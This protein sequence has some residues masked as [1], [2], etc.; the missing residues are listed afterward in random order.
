M[1]VGVALE[2]SVMSTLQ[3]AMDMLKRFSAP[4]GT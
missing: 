3:D 2:E 1:V 4:A